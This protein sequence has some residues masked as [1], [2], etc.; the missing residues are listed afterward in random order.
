MNLAGLASLSAVPE[1]GTWYRCVAP[2]FQLSAL[3]AQH[4]L[5]VRSRFSAGR[6]GSP[7]F[8]TL[9]FAE[10]SILGAFEIGAVYGS[11]SSPLSNPKKSFTLLCVKVRLSHVIDISG[12]SAQASIGTTAQELLG[13]LM[14]FLA[15]DNL[16]VN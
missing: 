7:P 3:S 14:G 5:S 9:Y 6:D 12:E 13:Y 2:Q 16:S 15:M 8:Q 1:T 4:T 11:P 10:N